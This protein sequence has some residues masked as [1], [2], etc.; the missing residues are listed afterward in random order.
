MPNFLCD[1]NDFVTDCTVKADLSSKFFHSVFSSAETDV[2]GCFSNHNSAIDSHDILSNV[3]IT[4]SE[5]ISELKNIN[6]TNLNP[7]LCP[8]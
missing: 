6:P 8:A 4:V 1:G 7:K 3:E 2:W 5:V